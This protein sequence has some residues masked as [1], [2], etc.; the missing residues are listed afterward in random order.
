MVNFND[1]KYERINYET[2]KS[3]IEYLINNLIEMSNYEEY[4]EICKK[5]NGLHKHI[6]EMY[7]YADIRNMRNLSDEYYK[8]EIDYWNEYKPK[9]DILFLPFYKE[10]I[11]SRFRDSL[12]KVMPSNFFSVI[13]CQI[14]IT[15]DEIVDLIKKENELK[16][17][18]RNLNRSKILFDGK[19][20]TISMISGL[21]S[22]KD[23]NIR[24]KAHDAVNDY[25]YSKQEEYDKTLYELVKV[26]N[27]IAKKL[28]FNNYIEYSLYKL[29]RFGYDYRDISLF[30]DNIIKYIV[31]ICRELSKWQ[32]EELGLNEL[33]YYDTV[34][35]E[36]MPKVKL[37]GNDLL[38]ELR[39]SFKEVD[40]ELSKLFNDML[41]NDYID[42]IQRD[43]KVSFAITNYLT[44]SAIPVITG[45]YKNSYLDVQ[46]TTHEMGHSFQKY[47]ASIKDRKYIVSPLLK[48]PTMEIAEMFSYSMELIMM[49]HVSNL[50]DEDDYKKYCFMKIYNL[51]SNLPY[52]CLVDE[53]QERIY[54][55][56]NLNVDDIR[57]IWLELVDKYQLN[58]SNK[59][60]I[61]LDTGGY[62]YRQSHIYLDPFY[63]IDYALSYFGALAIWSDSDKNLD[64]FKEIGEVASYYSFNELIDKYN[65]PNP[66]EEDNVKDI[67]IK[68]KEELTKNKLVRKWYK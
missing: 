57:K 16:T 25:Y 7:D 29:K 50:F 67:S 56:N 38:E 9:F 54:S 31:P 11:N 49:K 26:R 33:T 1:I 15:S 10:M 27:D 3:E 43:D 40:L 21:F 30:R 18:Y 51:V 22:N 44:E 14:R 6:E 17:K 52:I 66:F 42:L 4:L 23:R 53:F 39:K 5:I 34:F 60:H 64:L 65:M 58:R 36:D 41:D 32:K 68:L 63:Y 48:Y 2:T 47:L 55:N 59:G 24:K 45:N 8:K 37:Y 28:N 35:F 46:T 12:E 20:K 61:N 19:E 62:L 13:E